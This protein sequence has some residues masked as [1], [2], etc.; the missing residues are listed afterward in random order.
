MFLYNINYP[1][2]QAGACCVRLLC[3]GLALIQCSQGGNG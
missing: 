1:A 3:L 2:K